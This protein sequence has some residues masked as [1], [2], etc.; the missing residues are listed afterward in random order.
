MRLRTEQGLEVSDKPIPVRDK[1]YSDSTRLALM[2][3][4]QNESIVADQPKAARDLPCG[5]IVYGYA[6][7]G[8][9]DRIQRLIL[10]PNRW[11]LHLTFR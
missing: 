10:N 2:V 5:N 6:E 1:V 7:M 3:G 8:G 11:A 4:Q 9:R